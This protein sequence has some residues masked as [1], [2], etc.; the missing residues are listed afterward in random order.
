MAEQAPEWSEETLNQARQRIIERLQCSEEE[1]ALRLRESW[2][3][4][5]Q[6]ILE[7]PEP[8]PNPLPLPPPNQQPTQDEDEHPVTGKKVIFRDFDVSAPIDD[9]IPHTPGQYAT[10]KI[11]N[12]EYVE[13]WYFTTE[14]CR[15]AS[16]A[17]P[18]TSDD[19]LGILKTDAG[20]A[21][22]PI[23][24]TKASPN[25]RA[26]EGL[27]WE[28]IMTARHNLIT[29]ANQVGWPEKH[30]YALAEFYIN[31]ESRKAKGHNTQALTLGAEGVL[32]GR[33][34]E[35]LL[36]VCNQFAPTLPSG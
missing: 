30:T 7:A 28:Q 8:P 26:D 17:S 22:Q 5:L 10:K 21:I 31:L 12:M 14:G 34:I 20:F 32:P 2:N 4:A 23:K 35:S 24:A 36:R 25:A 16:R 15:E 33:Q 19:T 3:N 29:V 18:S 9:E 1:A 11:E 27:S 6:A 13:L